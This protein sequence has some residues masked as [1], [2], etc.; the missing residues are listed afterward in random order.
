MVQPGG[1]VAVCESCGVRYSIGRMREKVQEITGTVR[2]EGAVQAR[3]TGTEDDVSQ[4]RSLLDKYY[5]A[6]DFQAAENIVKKI[7]EAVPSDEQ[8]N[9]IYDD[10]QVLKFMEIKNGV[11]VKYT[12]LSETLTIPNCVKKIAE[13]AFEKCS[14]LKDVR[15]PNSVTEIGY[16]AFQGAIGLQSIIIPN[17]VTA[18]RGYAFK[19]TSLQ[20]VV[21]PN[22]VIQIGPHAFDC[23]CL[24]SVTIPDHFDDKYKEHIFG[25]EENY[26]EFSSRYE[27]SCPWYIRYRNEAEEKRQIE[28][29]KSEGRCQYCGWRFSVFTGKCKH[30]GKPKDY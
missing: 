1:Q 29:R 20:S 24:E 19:G 6:G 30:C 9:K 12:G 10:L 16:C 27:S 15:I 22:S 5:A 23:P 2:V 8:A 7:L 28:W 26:D 25:G 14:T 13:R 17:S 11:L 4:W 21:I 3:Q 18:I